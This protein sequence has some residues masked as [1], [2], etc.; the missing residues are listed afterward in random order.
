MS[1]PTTR[2]PVAIFNSRAEFIDGLRDALEREGLPTATALLAE[3]QDGTLDLVAFL[4]AH[5]PRVIVYDLPCPFE[6]HWNFLRLLRQADAR[7]KRTWILTTTD[8]R[9]LDAAVGAS[10]VLEVVFGEPYSIGEV[11]DAIRHALSDGRAPRPERQ[12]R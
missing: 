3:I 2:T 12:R 4:E 9:A 8:K 1:R 10:G 7:R 11:V 6:R 5:D